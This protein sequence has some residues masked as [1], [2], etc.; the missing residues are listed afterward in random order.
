MSGNFHPILLCA[1]PGIQHTVARLQNLVLVNGACVSCGSTSELI[2]TSLVGFWHN[3]VLFL[4]RG[5]S[6]GIKIEL[7]LMTFAFYWGFTSSHIFK[8]CKLTSWKWSFIIKKLY[9]TD[10]SHY[11]ITIVTRAK[12][13][14]QTIYRLSQLLNHAW[15]FRSVNL[16]VWQQWH[17]QSEAGEQNKLVKLQPTAR[18][19]IALF[20]VVPG[21]ILWRWLCAL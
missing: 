21:A 14:A 8:L 12:L 9:L 11:G 15:P 3:T 13:S 10:H 16:N 5:W 6:D 1:L 17:Q 2:S 18:P 4:N 20:L 7:W 19:K